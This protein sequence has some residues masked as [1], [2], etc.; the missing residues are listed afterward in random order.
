MADTGLRLLHRGKGKEIDIPQVVLWSSSR[1][2]GR[3]EK[4]N[5]SITGYGMGSSELY[6]YKVYWMMHS[7]CAAVY[8]ETKRKSLTSNGRIEEASDL[9]LR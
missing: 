6:E 4:R 1:V 3:L 5:D 8:L 7:I 2:E 9:A